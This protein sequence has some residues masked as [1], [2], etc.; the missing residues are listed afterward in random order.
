MAEIS[1]KKEQL[2]QIKKDR[3]KQFLKTFFAGKQ[4][5]VGTVILII[6]VLGA[7]CAPLISPYNPNEQNLMN[8]LAKPGTEHWFGTDDL[9]RDIFSRIIYGS[10][11]SM[12]V[13]LVSTAIA[14]VCGMIIGLIAGYFGGKI[15][16][17]IMR[18]MDAM[19]SV[20]VV[21]LALVIGSILG[22]GLFNI[23][24]CIGI[25]MIP[26]YARTT[27]GQVLQVKQLD[28]VI[29]GKLGGAKA[30][31]NAFKHVLPNCL[32]PNLVLMTMNMGSAILTEASL[33]FLGM[34]I[35]PPTATW[36]AMVSGGYRYLSTEPWIAIIPGLFVLI[37]VWAFN[38]C[39]D[40]V[41]DALDPKLSK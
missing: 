18:I 22:K 20:P 9:G 28:Y 1:A 16:A 10:R 11:I 40:A 21:I 2:K 34:G 30:M 14:G 19:M 15:D 35:N 39:G 8:A 37:T 24:L 7:I 6:V 12:I 17:I 5:Y 4:V 26:A 32:A 13:A 38:I 23:C 41:R 3:R 25:V 36:G 29:A 31:K 33:S 27:R